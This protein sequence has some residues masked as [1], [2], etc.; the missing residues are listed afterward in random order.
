MHTCICYSTNW[1]PVGSRIL[2]VQ[3]GI[4]I[5]AIYLGWE[6]LLLPLLNSR[7]WFGPVNLNF[8]FEDWWYQLQMERNYHYKKKISKDKVIKYD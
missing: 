3:I 7:I 6:C 2:L 1:N 5:K 8:H 4:P